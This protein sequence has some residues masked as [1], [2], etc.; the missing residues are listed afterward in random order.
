[1]NHASLFSGIGGFDLAAQRVG[2]KNIFSVEKDLFCNMILKKHFPETKR[3]FDIKKFR[4][5]IYAGSVD[6]ISGGFPCQPFSVAGKRRGSSDDR[7]LWGEMFRVISEIKPKWIV[8]ENVP[9]F[10]NIENGVVFEQTIIDLE[11]AGYEVESFIIPALAVNAPHRRDRVW[12]IANSNSKQRERKKKRFRKITINGFRINTD[13]LRAGCS[14]RVS[15]QEKKARAEKRRDNIARYVR[16]DQDWPE[17][18]TEFC[19]IYDGIPNRTHRFKSLGNSIV[20]Q[21]AEKIFQAI[22]GAETEIGG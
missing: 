22:K 8:A 10:V 15:G 4:G 12:I 3:Y 7:Y 11:S 19:R 9:G 21:I 17:V 14:N 13:T 20:P 2:F 5:E 18:A 1:M 6:I 16:W